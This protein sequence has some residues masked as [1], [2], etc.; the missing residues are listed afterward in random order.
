MNN[1]LLDT[2]NE[3]NNGGLINTMDLFSMLSSNHN[4]C[5]MTREKTVELAAE[6]VVETSLVRSSPSEMENYIRCELARK[7][8]E[9]LI[10]EDLIPMLVDN[11]IETLTTKVRTKIKVIQE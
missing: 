2:I 8:A 7:L 1:K 4:A 6:C 11:D 10:A 3:Y 5:T 9:Q